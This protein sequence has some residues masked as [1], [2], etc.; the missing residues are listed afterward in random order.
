MFFYVVTQ[1][2]VPVGELAVSHIPCPHCHA[3]RLRMQF[4]NLREDSFFHTFTNMPAIPLVVCTACHTQ[5]E[6]NDFS[7]PMTD[8]YR[9]HQKGYRGKFRFWFKWKFVAGVAIAI[10]AIGVLQFKFNTDAQASNDRAALVKQHLAHPVVGDIFE[11]WVV[12]EPNTSQ[13]APKVVQRW[14]KLIRIDGDVLVMQQD[15]REYSLTKDKP[16]QNVQ[17]NDDSFAPAELKFQLKYG[18]LYPL[19]GKEAMSVWSV[20]TAS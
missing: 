19:D 8:F 7:K 16:H 15:T 2:H 12:T 3:E 13:A 1:T 14:F 17:V 11:A 5:I 20:T 18:G 6:R 10:T 9:Q 4:F